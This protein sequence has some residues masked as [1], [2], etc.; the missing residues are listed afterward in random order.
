MRKLGSLDNLGLVSD[1]LWPL[2]AANWSYL[3]STCV[4]L[5]G[6]KERQLLLT[7][8]SPPRRPAA[9]SDPSDMEFFL[10]PLRV[11]EDSC[12]PPTSLPSLQ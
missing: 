6:R 12:S 4:R 7:T 5:L 9:A 8:L 10:S 11:T 1:G 3:V 2:C